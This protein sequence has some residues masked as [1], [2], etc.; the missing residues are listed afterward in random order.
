ADIEPVRNGERTD[1][2]M[3]GLK[4]VC[5]R[6]EYRREIRV[7]LMPRSVGQLLNADAV[8]KSRRACASGIGRHPRALHSTSAAAGRVRDKVEIK[9]R[10]EI[11]FNLV[12]TR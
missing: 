5:R 2:L 6:G 8:C 10:R 1:A 4:R 3:V 12:N 9:R 11:D 7:P